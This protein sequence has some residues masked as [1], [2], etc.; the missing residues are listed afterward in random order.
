MSVAFAV[1]VVVDGEPF[2]PADLIDAVSTLTSAG[3]LQVDRVGNTVRFTADE[4]PTLGDLAEPLFTWWQRQ[5]SGA[6]LRLVGPAGSQDISY[7]VPGRAVEILR[8]IIETESG[9]I[10]EADEENVA[11]GALRHIW[12]RRTHGAFTAQVIGVTDEGGILSVG[13]AERRD[14]TSRNLI[15]QGVDPASENAELLSDE[16]GYCLATET[17][18]T[19]YGGT[20]RSRFPGDHGLPEEGHRRAGRGVHRQDVGGSAG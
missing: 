10:R 9:P 1:S 6:V 14:G 3:P 5:G 17:A 16:E 2:D 4:R 18:A 11:P 20:A 15:L 19:V 7:M 13:V 12:G 8:Q